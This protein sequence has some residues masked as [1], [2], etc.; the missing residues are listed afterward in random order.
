IGALSIALDRVRYGL[1]DTT[2]ESVDQIQEARSIVKRLLEETRRLISDL[3]PLALE[4]LG[5][6]PAIRWY[7]ETHLQEQGVQTT[8]EVDQPAAR[9]PSH[10][11]IALFRIAQEA[12]NNIARHACARQ[13]RV[14]L[15]FRN[16][17]ARVLVADDGKGFDVARVLG[18]GPSGQSVGLLG[19]QERTRLLNGRI[20][21]HSEEGKGTQ[22][23]VEVPI[24][25][26]E[27]RR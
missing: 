11:E 22:L 2:G 20:D 8:I 4:D 7:A 10:L 15:F 16:S 12:I 26:A 5:L 18:P 1:Q 24:P 6:A 3:R 14:Q 9:L 17:T 27:E 19:M 25:G 13:A 21:I 23:I